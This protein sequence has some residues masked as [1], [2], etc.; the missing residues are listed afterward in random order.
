MACRPVSFS[1][2]STPTVYTKNASGE[3]TV[4]SQCTLWEC[5]DE[6]T[7][8][9]YRRY[10]GVPRNPGTAQV[11][12]YVNDCTCGGTSPCRAGDVLPPYPYW[13]PYRGYYP[14]Y[15]SYGDPDGFGCPIEDRQVCLR[16]AGPSYFC[17]PAYP[18]NQRPGDPPGCYVGASDPCNLRSSGVNFSPTSP[19][20]LVSCCPGSRDL[21]W[22][23]QS[24]FFPNLPPVR[25]WWMNG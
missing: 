2:D 15:P 14:P 6:G 5:G 7:A 23:A 11:Q 12:C 25:P 1:Q 22:S 18:G 9:G 21:P 24:Y 4:S 8:Y 19:G 3:C 17:T 10:V 20:C 16:Q 13:P